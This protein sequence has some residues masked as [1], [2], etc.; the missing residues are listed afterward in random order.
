MN[1][2][3]DKKSGKRNDKKKKTNKKT[4]RKKSKDKNNNNYTGQQL[5]EALWLPAQNKAKFIYLEEQ[6]IE[7]SAIT[8]SSLLI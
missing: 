5:P 6:I 1:K 8:T 2:N 4:N 7:I 3:R